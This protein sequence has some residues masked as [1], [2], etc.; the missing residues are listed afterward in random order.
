MSAE[1]NKVD[2]LAGIERI[3]DMLVIPAYKFLV[4]RVTI[5]EMNS[6]S[7][8]SEEGAYQMQTRVSYQVMP[9]PHYRAPSFGVSSG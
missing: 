4:R 5:E 7:W 2:A 6:V 3:G 8:D 9:Y 1:E